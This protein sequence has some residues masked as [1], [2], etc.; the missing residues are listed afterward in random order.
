M[1]EIQKF[2]RGCL[3][4]AI[5]AYQFALSPWF[6]PACRYE[7][8]CSEY[9]VEAITRHGVLRGTRLAGSRLGRCHPLGN[10]GY[11]PVP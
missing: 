1:R 7:P 6:G 4:L 9:A 10:S 8:R 3:L 11:D 2:F 5:R